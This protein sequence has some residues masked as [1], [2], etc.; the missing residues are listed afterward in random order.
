MSASQQGQRILIT[1]ATGAIGSALARDYARPGNELVLQGRRTKALEE[2]ATACRHNGCDSVRTNTLDLADDGERQAWL[3]QVRKDGLPD[4]VIANAGVNRHPQSGD[5]VE[6]EE[7]TAHLLAVNLQ[8][9]LA[10]AAA[11]IP[12]MAERGS[13]RFVFISS[14]AAWH[15]LPVTPS[16]SA[17]KAAIKAYGEAMDGRLKDRGVGVSVVIA[18]YIDSPMARAMP[19]P[20]PFLQSPERAAYRIRRGIERNRSRISFPLLLD[21]GCRCLA[22]MPAG[23]ARRLLSWLGYASR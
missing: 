23:L 15:G 6:H 14:L 16:Y 3:D 11:L 4:I 13:G 9:P 1:G 20:K 2:L 22:V 10:M 18:G 17:S 21:L 8:A 5:V 19:G 7:E 12:A